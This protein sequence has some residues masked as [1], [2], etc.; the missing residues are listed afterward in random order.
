MPSY[1]KKMAWKTITMTNLSHPA[2]RFSMADAEKLGEQLFNVTGTAAP[3][4]GERDRNYRLQT[5]T[6]AGWILK[7][8]NSTEP[9]VES[10]FQAAILSHLASYS[11]ELNPEERLN[12]DLKQAIGSQVPVRTKAKLRAA[13][14]EHMTMLQNT[15]ERVKKYFGDKHVAYA[16]S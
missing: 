11:P 12:A 9:R 14:T 2:P 10:E 7:V 13:A 3:L 15:P 16:A 5:G 6:G 4:D 8:V 1:L